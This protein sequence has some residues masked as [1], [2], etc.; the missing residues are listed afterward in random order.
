MPAA[1]VAAVIPIFGGLIANRI[2]ADAVEEMINQPFQK[3]SIDS[4]VLTMKVEKIEEIIETYHRFESYLL[5]V[6]LIQKQG[7][8]FKNWLE[9]VPNTEI[10]E[11]TSETIPII[12][13][14][15]I[16]ENLA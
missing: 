16:S 4:L 5:E 1:V 2:V 15:T 6:Q 7:I 11:A 10:Q 14:K 12:L 3:A 9:L 13:L 8:S